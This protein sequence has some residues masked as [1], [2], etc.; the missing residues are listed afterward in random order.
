LKKPLTLS[1]PSIHR[2]F[3]AGYKEVWH[4]KPQFIDAL[5]LALAVYPEAVV[6]VTRKAVTLHP[7]PPPV[8]DN[9]LISLR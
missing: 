1:W 9:R 5:K 6:D 4:L 7:S 2:Q 3:G 8:S